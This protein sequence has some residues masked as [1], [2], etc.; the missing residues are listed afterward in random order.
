MII[1]KIKLSNYT[2][3]VFI[4]FII[5]FLSIFFVYPIGRILIGSIYSDNKF[6]LNYILSFVTSEYYNFLILNTISVSLVSTLGSIFFGVIFGWVFHT[7]N[8][9]AHKFLKTLL[10]L[11][12][13]FPPFVGAIGIQQILARYGTI[14]LLLRDIFPTLD[15]FDWLAPG[16]PWAVI[17][18]QSLH[19]FPLVSLDVLAKLKSINNEYDEAAKMVG[20][21]TITRLLRIKLPL[22]M[23]SIKS[24]G[25]LVFISHFTDL[26]TPL[27]LGYQDVLAVK[28]FSLFLDSDSNPTSYILVSFTTIIAILLAFLGQTSFNNKKYYTQSTSKPSEKIRLSILTGTILA[29]FIFTIEFVSLLPH[30]GV[31]I[32]S[33]AEKWF[34]TPF[35]T[36]ITYQHYREVFSHP[37]TITGLEISLVLAL[38]SSFLDLFFGFSIC[39]IRYRTK[40][41]LGKILELLS[42]APIAIP[43]IIIAFGYAKSFSG[44]LLDNKVNP[45]PLLVLA[46]TIRRLPFM[47]KLLSSGFSYIDISLEEVAKVSGIGFFKRIFKILFPLIMPNIMAGMLLCFSFAVIEVSDSL[48]LAIEEKYYPV[49]KVLYVLAGRPDGAPLASA[50]GVIILLVVMLNVLIANLII[51]KRKTSKNS[52]ILRIVV[53]ICFSVPTIGLTEK[54]NSNELVILSPHWEGFKQEVEIGFKKYSKTKVNFRWLDVGGTSDILR[55]IQSEYEQHRESIGIDLLFG[56]GTDP[57][58]T[59]NNKNLLQKAEISSNILNKIPKELLGSPLFDPYF[60]WFSISIAG[61]GI[62]YNKT[63][64]NEQKLKIPRSWK[65]FAQPDNYSW[66]TIADPRKSGS[67]H[68]IFELILQVYG[69]EEGWRVLYGMTHNVRQFHS[70]SSLIPHSIAVGE[71]AIGPVIDSYAFHALKE[72]G[73]KHIGFTIPESESTLNGDGIAILKGAPNKDLAIKFIEYLLSEDAQKMLFTRVG[74]SG[75]P[76][77][78]TLNKLSILP[79]VYEKYSSKSEIIINPFKFKSSFKYNAELATKR[80]I[81][82]NELI[83]SFLV[84][85]HQALQIMPI[86]EVLKLTPPVSEQTMN[87]LIDNWNDDSFRLKY[88]S[89]WNSESRIKIPD[90]SSFWLIFKLFILGIIAGYFI[91]IVIKLVKKVGL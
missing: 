44:T 2:G 51:N 74:T 76:I 20:T 26:G 15:A 64:I 65:D 61:F 72:V 16:N 63:I 33:F 39:F 38:I 66:V 85:R 13:F 67:M 12:L 32:L 60:K 90:T 19:L 79:L 88:I 21:S 8:F 91:F 45:L 1:N 78:Y 36:E 53:L 52:Y 35:P 37:L 14:N 46:Y 5:L 17:I 18:L 55:Y 6:T 81:I 9:T 25:I 68:L 23:P 86:N 41:Y 54:T 3:F 34:L 80:W 11:P 83:G 28:I 7:F 62:L 75:G 59:L 29:I 27:L 69:W 40:A 71:V 57:F 77:N 24:V 73:E 56:G 43:G 50:L 82:I 89:K 84:E 42:L 30:F 87:N 4:S 31:I 49:S 10:I 58:I 47:V 22:L 48:F 70:A